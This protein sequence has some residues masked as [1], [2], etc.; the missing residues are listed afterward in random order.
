MSSA[1]YFQIMTNYFLQY[2]TIIVF[3]N[4]INMT[5][6]QNVGNILNYLS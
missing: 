1:Y 4:F 3:S 6:R 5:L 2:N